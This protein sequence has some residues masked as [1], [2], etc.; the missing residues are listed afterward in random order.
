MTVQEAKE[1]ITPDL[2]SGIIDEHLINRS[3]RKYY[4]IS[5]KGKLLELGNG[6]ILFDSRQQAIKGFY[7]SY[8]WRTSW[9][10]TRRLFGPSARWWEHS[11]VI[12]KAFTEKLK[13]EYGFQVV[14][15]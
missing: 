4:A 14:E 12:W 7:N 2:I 5:V 6:K 13:R 1:L 11:A 15:V 9:T 10:L 8:R 3:N